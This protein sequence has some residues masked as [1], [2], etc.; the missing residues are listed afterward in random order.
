MRLP[1]R[2]STHRPVSHASTPSL[3]DSSSRFACVYPIP[4]RLD[5]PF[6]MR[7]PHR[8]STRRPVWHASDPPPIDSSSRLAWS[9]PSPIDSISRFGM[10]RTF[11]DRLDLPF[12]DGLYHP[13]STR[14]PVSRWSGP[15]LI[16]SSSRFGMVFTIPD[17]L[18]VLFWDGLYHPLPNGCLG[19]AR[20][21]ANS[22]TG[23]RSRW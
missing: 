3:I 21:R 5:L 6:R 23:L 12:R 4:D 19:S 13:R 11:P 14:R 7:L 17:R 1:H 20:S 2:R 18:V 8:R 10:V 16:D 9:G 22:Y 15:S